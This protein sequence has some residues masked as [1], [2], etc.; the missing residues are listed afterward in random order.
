MTTSTRQT[1]RELMIDQ[2]GLGRRG[3]N[4]GTSASQITDTGFAGKGRDEGVDVGSA[5]MIT[6]GGAAPED[7]I[8][9]VNSRPVEA[10]GVIALSPSLSAALAN[11]DT[12]EILRRPLV[13]DAGDGQNSLH[14]ALSQTMTQFRFEKR[15]TPLTMVTDGDMRA[16]G[17]TDWTVTTATR[18]K[19]AGSFPYGLDELSVT[20]GA[21]NDY[22]RTAS[23]AVDED[24]TYYLEATG[25]QVTG[26]GGGTLVLHDV[27]NAAAIT[28]DESSITLR[29]PETLV[30]KSV[31]IPSGCKQ[32]QVR[33]T[34]I[35]NTDVIYWS[36][37]ILR[38]NSARNFAIAD[39]PVQV[40]DIGN[41]MY[42]RTD[43]FFDRGEPVPVAMGKP[44]QT[45]G[46]TW[47]I[48]TDAHVSGLSLWYE[49]FT[50]PADLTSDSST[51][52]VPAEAVAAVA[53]ELLLR[54]L[55]LQDPARWAAW[56]QKASQAAARYLT[57]Y[58]AQL[59]TYVTNG[60]RRHA[61]ARL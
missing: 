40:L 42:Y 52:S 5:V 58:H 53:A 29:E 46:G 14:R 54:P 50:H 7:E 16:S 59:R 6:S 51:T 56:W 55:A 1:I 49:E 38:P 28:L 10:T 25:R 34:T 61:L 24:D 22:A 57:E 17:V 3:T 9:A 44:E 13:F 21:A 30:N 26:T 19:V 18:A 8:T 36:N 20:A 23:I 33:P 43:E 27:T 12:F 47:R 2:Y 32:V 48:R 37:V 4:S 35:T 11:T 60:P 15:L 45:A 39:R 41:L 31:S